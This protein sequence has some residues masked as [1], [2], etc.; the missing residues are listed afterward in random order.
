MPTARLLEMLGLP[1]EEEAL[2]R[3]SVRKRGS[4][5]T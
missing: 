1:A 3:G 5:Y 2:M 4:T